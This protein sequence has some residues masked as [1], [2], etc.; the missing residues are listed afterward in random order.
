MTEMIWCLSFSDWRIFLNIIPSGFLMAYIRD[1][2]WGSGSCHG[3]GGGVPGMGQLEHAHT[4]PG[5]EGESA[6]QK[7]EGW[8]I[9]E[10]L[11]QS[12]TLNE[13]DKMQDQGIITECKV[14]KLNNGRTKNNCGKL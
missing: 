12:I 10:R 13:A 5:R 8:E 11:P 3:R 1:Q 14:I 9:R 4:H 7:K 6:S 2:A